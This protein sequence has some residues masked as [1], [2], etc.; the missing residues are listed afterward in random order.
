M[1]RERV[2][3]MLGGFFGVLALLLSAVGL[4]GVTSYSV[5]LRRGEIGVR[6]A[7]GADISR[8]LRLV[9]GGATRLVLI[10]VAVGI[11]LSLWLATFVGPLLY[12]LESRDPA[13]LVAAVL[14][15]LII[16]TAAAFVPAW[17]AARIEP[18]EVLRES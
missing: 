14:V 7:L 11:G 12:G 16:G 18:I 8:V 6:M 13:T 10:G 4:Y 1:V 17:R 5:N 9:L 15:M 3:A 2:M